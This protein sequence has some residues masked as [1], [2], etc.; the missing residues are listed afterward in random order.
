MVKLLAFSAVLCA[1]VGAAPAQQSA[2]CDLGRPI[3]ERQLIRPKPGTFYSVDV[4]NPDIVRWRGRYLLFFSGN[5]VHHAQGL[6]RTGVAVARTPLGPFRVDRRLRAEF[7]NGG[8]AAWRGR[9]VQG[10]DWPTSSWF[11]WPMLYESRDG[12]DWRRVS[13]MPMSPNSRRWDSIIS[14]LSVDPR[15]GR[16][17]VYFAGR[18]GQT[19]ADL[20]VRRYSNGRWGRTR[21]VLRRGGPGTFDAFD[22]GEPEIFRARGQT[23]LVY[24]AM[25]GFPAAE[26]RPRPAHRDRLAAVWQRAADR[27]PPALVVRA[28]RHRSVAARGR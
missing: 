19:G 22:L 16:L 27:R 5:S 24:S 18:T 2:P 23:Y 15:G 28:E 17:D 13:T 7:F 20:G 6:W 10:V 26:N 4:L 14:D 25:A 9:L 21:L 3:L 11:P 1:L 12:I 8:T